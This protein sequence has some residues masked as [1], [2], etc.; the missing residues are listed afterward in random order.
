ML[1]LTKKTEYALIALCHL[2]RTEESVVSAR[3]IAAKY[4][5]PLPLLMNVLKTLHQSGQVQSARG[6]HGGYRLAMPAD[7]IKLVDLVEAIDG[8]V[9]LVRCVTPLPAGE[10]G[11]ELTRTC[12]IRRPVNRLHEQLRNFLAGVTIADLAFDSCC[13]ADATF[14]PLKVLKS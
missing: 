1:S 12:P 9:R 5:V 4:G 3:D 2:A 14:Q 13:A 8:P 6:A 11:C 10:E 7:Q